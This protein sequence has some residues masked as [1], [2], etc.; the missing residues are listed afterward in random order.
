[1]GRSKQLQGAK[2]DDPNQRRCPLWRTQSL[3]QRL[4]A[5]RQ[6]IDVAILVFEML[7]YRKSK[8]VSFAKLLLIPLAFLLK[9]MI[10]TMAILSTE[11]G[12]TER[13]VFYYAIA[14]LPATLVFTTGSAIPVNLFI[15]VMIA[16]IIW[17]VKRRRLP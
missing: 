11:P 4:D 14:L 10:A 1:M 8:P 16:V 13:A 2:G 7:E 12:I 6:R 3:E 5:A 15:G 17:L 9:D